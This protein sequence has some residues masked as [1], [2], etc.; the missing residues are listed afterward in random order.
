MS[1]NGKT[2][3]GRMSGQE[4]SAG[5]EAGCGGIQ[6]QL[7]RILASEQFDA[8]ERN[9]RFLTYVVDEATQGRG[10]RIKAYSIAVS[11]FGRDA[12]FDPQQ[13]SIVRIEAGRLRRSLERYYLTDGAQDRIRISIPR[14]SYVPLFESRDASASAEVVPL[15]GRPIGPAPSQQPGIAIHVRPFEEDRATTGLTS[16]TRGL[17]R[18]I[19]VG[20]TRFTDLAVFSHDAAAAQHST[21]FVVSGGVTLIDDGFGLEVLLQDTRTGRLVWGD[22]FERKLEPTQILAVRDEVANS[23][24][25]S[26][27]Q[28]YGILFGA[29][30]RASE[31]QPPESMASYDAVIQFYRYWHSYDPGLFEPVRA[32]LERAILA[33][34]AYAE[35]HAC[36]SL[37]YSN[38]ARFGIVV[39]GVEPLGRA[40][41]L[42]RRAIEL[43]PQSSRAHHALSNALWFGGDVQTGL[44]AIESGWALNPNDTDIMADLGMRYAA[45]MMW[46]KAIPLLENSYARNPGQPGIYRAALALYHFAH[47]RFRE[48]LAEARR[49][50]AP[51]NIYAYILVAISAVELGLHQEADAAMQGILAVDPDYGRRT[52]ADLQQRNIHPE[53]AA[54]VM[55]GLRKAGLPGLDEPLAA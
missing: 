27:A 50:G 49:I 10:D 32:A 15:S 53:L 28:P 39:S 30:A 21:D 18:Q 25:R 40:L 26:L 51:R 41:A 48:A 13:D 12:G 38:A 37:T 5:S 44:A 46:D 11:V 22:S 31:G 33:D 2:A 1:A 6:V 20:L 7:N 55:A 9:R 3:A 16:F 45:R 54:T 43:A 29:R 17:T 19:I 42:A 24:V 35:A 8:S 23:I 47:G 14:G 34:P 4:F 52:A 36:L